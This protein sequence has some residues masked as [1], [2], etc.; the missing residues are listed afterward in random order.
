[1]PPR[2]EPLPKLD[3][4][5]LIRDHGIRL[6]GPV[7]PKKWP[8]EH[9]HHFRVIRRIEA[10]RYEDYKVDQTIPKEQRADF[11]TRVNYLR[12]KVYNLLDNGKANESTWRELEVTILKRFDDSVI[13]EKCHHELWKSNF[14]ANFLHS[15][16][17]DK[18]EAKR[19]QRRLC[20]CKIKR[21]ISR[22]ENEYFPSSLQ[23]MY[24]ADIRSDDENRAIF[25]F[26]KEEVFYHALNDNLEN[27]SISMKPDRVIG[28]RAP[29]YIPQNVTFFPVKARRILLPFLVVEAKKEDG[30]PGFRAIQYQTAF[31][32]RRLLKAQNDLLGREVSAEP[33]LVWF[34]GYQGEQ[35]RLH[36]GTYRNDRRIYDLWQGTIQSQDGALQLLLIVDFIWSWARDIYRP[37]VRNLLLDMVKS[38]RDSSPAS[39]DRFRQSVSLSS[40]ASPTPTNLDLEVMQVDGVVAGTDHRCP[41]ASHHR[42]ETEHASQESQEQGPTA[43]QDADSHAFL[44]W[45]VGHPLA[46]SWTEIGSIRHANIVHFDFK[47]HVFWKP[48]IVQVE[49]ED[50]DFC[51]VF[52][53]LQSSAFL[54]YPRQLRELVALWTTKSIQIPSPNVTKPTRASFYFHTYCD[55]ST[56]QIKRVLN[57]VLWGAAP[58]TVKNTSA[59]EQLPAMIGDD[60]IPEFFAWTDFKDACSD[61][62]QIYGKDSV[63]YA[64]QTT[65]MLLLPGEE[66]RRP[67]WVSFETLNIPKTAAWT[68]M[69]IS[70]RTNLGGEM[71]IDSVSLC[72]GLS[73]VDPTSE[74]RLRST[75]PDLGRDTRQGDSMI[76][77]RS[78][79]W[80]A[81]CP[82]F[83]LFVLLKEDYDDKDILHRH[84]EEAVALSNYYA[85]EGYEFSRS[86]WRLLHNWRRALKIETI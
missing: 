77:V 24:R 53:S 2:K 3:L 28:L 42:T 57:C 41:R 72:G 36:A 56:W 38:F 45:A 86:C 55:Q 46:P 18:L 10:I 26:A 63:W 60:D 79:S 52:K 14:E 43:I 64:L 29:S 30:V 59:M 51:S 70:K 33:C 67:E 23:C 80:P 12:E 58:R 34:F 73:E 75:I 4:R 61:A 32:V 85:E 47:Y 81:T 19:L 84:L 22:A 44:K 49:Q 83:C 65:S 31:P 20:G 82:Q 35:W 71:V 9:K 27:L 7:P 13:C 76:A 8:P 11:K 25:D 17:Q 6:E 21:T 69:D 5:Q 66:S 40:A 68:L 15:D 50:V 1:M 37:T 54:M 16:N 39:T 74:R 62:Q 48:E 78:P